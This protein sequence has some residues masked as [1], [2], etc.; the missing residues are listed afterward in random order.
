VS[1]LLGFST[2]FRQALSLS[3]FHILIFSALSL[4]AGWLSHRWRAYFI[5]IASLLAAYWIQPATPVRHLDFWFPTASIF[6]TILVWAS[7]RQ[8]SPPDVR[9]TLRQI[10][11]IIGIVILVGLTRYLGPVCCLTATRPPEIFQVI[12]ASL[13][14]AIV[15][16]IILA[17]ANR[18]YS[19]VLV[20]VLLVAV[21]ICLKMESLAQLMSAALRRLQGQDISLASA[22]DLRWLGFSYLAFRLLHVL[23]DSRLGKAQDISLQEFTSYALFFPALT[24]G[25]I[26]R[27]QRFISDLR[28]ETRM[29][30]ETL[31]EGG[32][33]ILLGVFKKFVVADSLA[34][35]A[36]SPQNAAQTAPGVWAWVLLYAYTLRIY[37]DFAGYTDIALGLGRWMGIKLP[38]NFIAPYFKTDL[39][40][41]W[42]SWHITLAQWFRSYFYN[43]LTRALRTSSTS[44]PVWLII[45][46]GQAGTMLLIGLW[47]GVTWNFAAWGL[48]HAL[49]LF[50]H[51]RWS[52]WA[53]PRVG[54]L[55]LS[56]T[57]RRLAS[58]GGWFLTFNYVTLGWVWFALPDISLSLAMFQKLFSL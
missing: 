22:L 19:A 51:N 57:V 28:G 48:W 49:G 37:F 8:N 14:I 41:F 33:R 15:L 5:L 46:A 39:T 55:E 40:A 13:L 30:P 32:Q 16:A 52:D 34:I 21:F 27:S 56:L 29:S 58:L 7:T 18:K 2:Q 23:R 47:H 35:I 45:L 24:A 11:P 20:F 50:V 3:L 10:A 9:L 38:E 36:L 54:S 12:A 4:L 6:I 44:L 25:P 53:R 43:P 26:D 31:L 17:R 42:N 1:C